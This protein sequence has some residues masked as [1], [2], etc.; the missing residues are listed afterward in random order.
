MIPLL[1][2]RRAGFEQAKLELSKNARSSGQVVEAEQVLLDGLR[3]YPNSIALLTELAEIASSREEWSLAAVRWVSVLEAHG[4]RAPAT[5]FVSAAIALRNSGSLEKAVRVAN[6]GLKVHRGNTA[7]IK[8]LTRSATTREDWTNAANLWQ[9][10]LQSEL[11]WVSSEAVAMLIRSRRNLGDFKAARLLLAEAQDKFPRDVRLLA[12]RAV[13][14]NYPQP[15]QAYDKDPPS[16]PPV[17]VVVCVYNALDQTRACLEALALSTATELITIVDDGSDEGVHEFLLQYTAEAPGR[18]LLRNETNQGYTKS[19]NRG[20][21]SARA[22]WVVLLNSDTLVTTGW[23]KGL[24]RCALSGPLIRAVGPMSNAATFQSLPWCNGEADVQSLNQVETQA[25]RVRKLSSRVFPKVPML[26][27]FCLMLHRPTLDEVGY[28]DEE[29]FPVGYG[30]E[31]DLCLRLFVAGY[32]LA[33]ADDTYVY[34]SR[35]ASFGCGKRKLLTR[36]AV[37]TLKRLWP[38]YSYHYISDVVQ[39][40]PA[41]RQLKAAQG[42]SR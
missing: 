24:L 36:S 35:S 40:I 21:K 2:R 26:N 17:E 12:E 25:A 6:T 29:N 33:I 30:E 34:H 32:Q 3:T 27:G 10:I 28:L 7:L 5:S 13:S 1:G 8:E 38:G 9:Q 39:E 41:L 11:G 31:N 15:K 16:Y 23:L 4:R 37:E 42:A 19:A 22:D 20:L 14:E 18:R